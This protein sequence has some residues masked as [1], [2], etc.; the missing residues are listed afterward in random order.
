MK[1]AALLSSIVLAACGTKATT[2]STTAGSAGSST[3]TTSG[4]ISNAIGQAVG[5]TCEQA[6]KDV[7]GSEGSKWYMRCPACDELTGTVWGTDLRTPMTR[8]FA[9]R[10]F[11]RAG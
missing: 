5:L 8:T 3:P 6:A 1:F 2:S 10:P 7:P 9:R 4:S 11:T